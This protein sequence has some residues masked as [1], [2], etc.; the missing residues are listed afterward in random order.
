[1]CGAGL[2]AQDGERAAELWWPVSTASKHVA[3]HRCIGGTSLAKAC[4]RW[5]TNPPV[6][7]QVTL[8]MSRADAKSS[9][10]VTEILALNW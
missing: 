2:E 10:C 8:A 1:M 9:S 7:L 3:S 5:F 4:L 6:L